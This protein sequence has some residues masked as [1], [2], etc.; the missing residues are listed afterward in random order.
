[1]AMAD[2]ERACAVA[3]VPDDGAVSVTVGE[4]PVAVVRSEGDVYA[5]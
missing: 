5:I 4:V 3:E 1:M 2:Y